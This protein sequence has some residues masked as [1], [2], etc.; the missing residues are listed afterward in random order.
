LAGSV[1]FIAFAKIKKDY[2]FWGPWEL[3]VLRQL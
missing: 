1:Y 2:R 3:S